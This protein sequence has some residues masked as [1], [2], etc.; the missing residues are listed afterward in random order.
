MSTNVLNPEVELINP[1]G[2]VIDVNVAESR[3]RISFPEKKSKSLLSPLIEARYSDNGNVRKLTIS[4]VVFISTNELEKLT[5]KVYQ[6]SYA[7]IEGIPQLQFF[8]AYDLKEN[9]ASEFDIYEITFDA[10]NIPFD[11][12]LSQIKKIETFLWDV[13]PV[14]SRGTVT[15][16]QAG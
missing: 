10:K 1:P 8:I 12:G 9:E 7:N 4:A 16:V 2:L 15:T 13:D 14:A 5:L 6:N 3:G 11:G